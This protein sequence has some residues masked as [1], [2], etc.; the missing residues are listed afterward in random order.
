[1]SSQINGSNY[2]MADAII[3]QTEKIRSGSGQAGPKTSTATGAAGNSFQEILNRQLQQQEITFSKHASSRTEERNIE[4]TRTDLT[5]LNEACDKAS[6][7]GI[8]DALVIT[9]KA[10]FIVNAPSKV[11]VTVID[12]NEMKDNVFTNIDGAVFI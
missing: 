7:K 9:D 3:R 12:K 1:M 8:K 11:V 6:K 4:M 2:S 5:K 10:A